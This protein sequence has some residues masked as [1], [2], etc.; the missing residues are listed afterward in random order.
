MFISKTAMAGMVLLIALLLQGCGRKGPLY[1][2]QAP[3]KPV[4]TVEPPV[5][6]SQVF[7]NPVIQSQPEATQQP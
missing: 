4:V 5:V 2:P 1:M 6:Q 7:P 3:A